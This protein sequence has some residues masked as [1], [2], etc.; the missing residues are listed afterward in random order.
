MPTVGT[1]GAAVRVG[2]GDAEAVGRADGEADAE[3][4]S[5]AE[6][7]GE[8]DGASE[9]VTFSDAL[10]VTVGTAARSSESSPWS[11]RP[12]AKAPA[13]TTAT[14]TAAASATT[15]P[16]RR[17]AGRS[18]PYPIAYS[19]AVPS[20]GAPG[21]VPGPAC[22]GK[23]HSGPWAASGPVS[24]ANPPTVPY[25]TSGRGACVGSAPAAGQAAA[26]PP[27]PGPPAPR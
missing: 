12:D 19:G 7:D 4:V 17:V 23:S 15:A 6:T 2:E 26:S 11:S 5:E 9:T 13:P 27:L 22:G 3:G 10:V 20:D 14:A 16:R 1:D 21:P 18:G 24:G 8:T 25:A